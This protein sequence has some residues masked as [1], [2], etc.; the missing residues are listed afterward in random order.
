MARDPIAGGRGG[1]GTGNARGETFRG[2]GK[3]R[4]G[5][6]EG[7]TEGK[8]LATRSRDDDDEGEEDGIVSDLI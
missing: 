4:N 5:A 2:G 8:G 6:R 1:E 7:R 3:E